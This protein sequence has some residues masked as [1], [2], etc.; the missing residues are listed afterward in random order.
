MCTFTPD[1]FYMTVCNV[2]QVK[3]YWRMMRAAHSIK[4]YVDWNGFR[5]AILSVQRYY[6]SVTPN[7]GLIANT[8]VK[9]KDVFTRLSN[10]SN[11]SFLVSRYHR[12]T[13][14]QQ[15]RW[16]TRGVREAQILY[17]R[18]DE[19]NLPGNNA[20]WGDSGETTNQTGQHGRTRTKEVW[21]ILSWAS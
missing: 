8:N 3:H 14:P 7:A 13:Y 4:K 5:K 9:G 10:I 18:Q 1:L 17:V 12:G 16:V 15:S 2:R 11:L 19:I 6:K 21:S 20:T